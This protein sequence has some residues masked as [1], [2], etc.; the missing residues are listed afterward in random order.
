MIET[1]FEISLPILKVDKEKRIVSGYATTD[2]IDKQNEQVDYEA[3]KEAFRDWAGNIREMH[4]PVAVGKAV[5]WEPDDEKRGIKVDAYISRGA[6]GTWEKI[7]DGTLKAFSIGGQTV[8]KTQQIVKDDAGTQ[9][10]VTKITKYKLTELSLV[11]NPANPDATFALVKMAGDIPTQTEIVEDMKKV[12]VSEQEDILEKE[13]KEHRSKA[14]SLV[15]KVLGSDELSKLDSENW[16]VIR[17]YEKEGTQYIERMLPM[18]DKVHAVRALAVMDS[19]SLTKE[20][21]DRVHDLAKSILGSDYETYAL[22]TN[23]GGEI[24]QMNKEILDALKELTKRVTSIEEKFSKANMETD[25]NLKTQ[26][27][28]QRGVPSNEQDQEKKPNMEGKVPTEGEKQTLPDNVASSAKPDLKTQEEGNVAPV[29]KEAEKKEEK[30]VEK[31]TMVPTGSKTI[32]GEKQDEL[33]PVKKAKDPAT[34]DLKTQEEGNVAPVKKD[35]DGEEKEETEEEK[36]AKKK[37]MSK[38]KDPATSDL[39]TMEDEN[40][41]PVKAKKSL[42]SED[43]KKSDD[44]IL[45]TLQTLSKRLDALESTPM[46]RKYHTIEKKF[47]NPEGSSDNGLAEDMSKCLELR[48]QERNG[49]KLTPD[50]VSFIEKTLTKSLNTKVS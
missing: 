41:P 32:E 15:K 43:V 17:K 12:L 38:A 42:E 50:E 16:G 1:K 24:K 14:D 13:V 3:S 23:R 4:S 10:H 19:Y 25:S 45:E 36:K 26:P 9:R 47:G 34:S 27:D 2:S 31:A 5:R 29:K 30:E 22:N 40:V 18:P 8:N 48:K 39:H 49:K 33:H 37:K 20:E 21:Q 44:V 46:P 11:D 6:Q 28:V 35:E 7:L